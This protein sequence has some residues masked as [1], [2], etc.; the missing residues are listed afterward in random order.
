MKGRNCAGGVT[1]IEVMI[2]AAMI[3]IVAAIVIP[4]FMLWKYRN[5]I[6]AIEVYDRAGSR[7]F[8]TE[9]K[10]KDM[11]FPDRETV[12]V[13]TN[14]GVIELHGEVDVN[15][16]NKIASDIA[17][18]PEDRRYVIIGGD[19]EGEDINLNRHK[20]LI[21]LKIETISKNGNKVKSINH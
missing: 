15:L 16:A 14:S 7:V 8:E 6:Y 13:Y 20:I 9:A 18:I 12:L 5:N 1:L 11:K 2:I 3:G 19:D 4:R 17:L 21:G 10:L